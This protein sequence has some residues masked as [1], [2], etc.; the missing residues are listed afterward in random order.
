MCVALVLPLFKQFLVVTCVPLP[1]AYLSP[2][3]F[4]FCARLAWLCWCVHGLVFYLLFYFTLHIFT[5]ISGSQQEIPQ[6]LRCY[7]LTHT[8]LLE[9]FRHPFIY[10]F[11]FIFNSKVAKGRPLLQ[12]FIKPGFLWLSVRTECSPQ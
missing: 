10:L 8:V 7:H 4:P 2:T 12:P 3:F 5:Y 9:K 11:F 6:Q 1:C